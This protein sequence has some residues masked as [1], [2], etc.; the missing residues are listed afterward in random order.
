MERRT[1]SSSVHPQK[2]FNKPLS[3]GSGAKQALRKI[4]QFRPPRNEA[5]PAKLARV[6]VPKVPARREYSRHRADL[7]DKNS[8]DEDYNQ[9]LMR[10]NSQRNL[11]ATYP[12]EKRL[13]EAA[14][15]PAART[16]MFGMSRS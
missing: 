7:D 4:T 6:V 15:K 8:E 10:R 2:V 5:R 11:W 14:K 13:E 1:E 12:K 3:T 9:R 16:G